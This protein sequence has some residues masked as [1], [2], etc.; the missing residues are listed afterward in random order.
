MV[1]VGGHL[2]GARLQ[3][4]L[5]P[6]HPPCRVTLLAAAADKAEQLGRCHHRVEC[7]LELLCVG[8]VRVE[9]AADIGPGESRAL[10][11]DGIKRDRWVLDDGFAISPGERF[12]LG[13]PFLH[14]E[15]AVTRGLLW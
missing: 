7:L 15:S 13:H 11:R 3:S 4:H 14:N 1:M 5:D 6:N 9:K 12:V 8:G 10:F 2:S